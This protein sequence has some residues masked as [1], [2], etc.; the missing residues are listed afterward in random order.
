VGSALSPVGLPSNLPRAASLGHFVFRL[1]NYIRCTPG[2]VASLLIV[3]L[4][5]PSPDVP[6]F[7]GI[8]LSVVPEILTVA[9]CIAW[10]TIPA[11]RTL[12]RGALSSYIVILALIGIA[13]KVILILAPTPGFQA[14][15]KV[16]SKPVSTNVLEK[17]Y[18]TNMLT[19]SL[20]S[21]CEKSYDAPFAADYSRYDDVIDFGPNDPS[22]TDIKGL[23]VSNW[24]V[25]AANSLYYAYGP[26]TQ[27]NLNRDRLALS[28]TWRSTLDPGPDRV[29]RY[30]GEGSISIGAFAL[31]LPPSYQEENQIVLPTTA[32]GA[33]LLDY[34]WAPRAQSGAEESAAPYGEVHLE[35]KAG[36]PVAPAEQSTWPAALALAFLITV[37]SAFAL[38]ILGVIGFLMSGM[39]NAPPQGSAMGFPSFD[40]LSAGDS[41]ANVAPSGTVP[42]N[43]Y[44]RRNPSVPTPHVSAGRPSLHAFPS[45]P[46]HSPGRSILRRATGTRLCRRNL[47]NRVG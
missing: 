7:D 24:N 13:L 47:P 14:C 20:N 39:T 22:R 43:R 45:L 28:A 35:S 16:L 29:I 30:V 33:M 10:A 46:R 5:M 18:G 9:F 3:A 15:Y 26:A 23:D 12:G 40:R 6:W 8:P 25:T 11:R 2:A 1:F 36:V 34:K 41:G 31:E 37:F 17:N 42:P 19:P 32:S 38:Q 4:V 44:G 27:S 21:G